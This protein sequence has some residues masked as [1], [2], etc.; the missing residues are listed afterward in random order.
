MKGP[1]TT[2][3]IISTLAASAL[4][5]QR[6]Q[7]AGKDGP[8]P[9]SVVDG[10]PATGQVVERFGV[11]F[12]DLTVNGRRL[13]V[14]DKAIGVNEQDDL[15]A[16]LRA[17]VVERE[18]RKAGGY[19][20]ME[21]A[22]AKEIF[23]LF[24]RADIRAE[25]TQSSPEAPYVYDN[26][27]YHGRGDKSRDY[28][29]NIP[30]GVTTEVLD[31]LKERGVTQFFVAAEDYKNGRFLF[32]MKSPNGVEAVPFEMSLEGLQVDQYGMMTH[33]DHAANA[34]RLWE[35]VPQVARVIA[36]KP[37]LVA[38]AAAPEKALAVGA[39]V[40]RTEVDVTYSGSAVPRTGSN[41]VGYT[42]T[43]DLKN[44]TADSQTITLNL[45]TGLPSFDRRDGVKLSAESGGM[46][47]STDGGKNWEPKAFGPGNKP[48]IVLAPNQDA[49]VEIWSL[50]DLGNHRVFE[51]QTNDPRKKATVT[52][53]VT[54][55]NGGSKTIPVE[56]SIHAGF[57]KEEVVKEKP[58]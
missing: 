11:K 56:T 3:A 29:Y 15:L 5:M 41:T 10:N 28:R 47:I 54:D 27:N 39:T 52:L 46:W 26:L 9:A 31:I 51:P 22:R 16:H 30:A 23:G 36:G 53:I 17:L 43:V 57:V 2:A 32:V 4:G 6:E 34:Q 21:A 40:T 12:R 19:P 44:S 33:K 42:A 37:Q 18:R 8:P 48:T 14:A 55:A 13:Y 49:R 45:R 38:P 58:H 25:W 7:P 1:A 35:T 20:I 24:D 50:G